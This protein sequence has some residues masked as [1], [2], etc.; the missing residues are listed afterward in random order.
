ML[1]K[2]LKKVTKRAKPKA[3]KSG[4]R[5]IAASPG[6]ARVNNYGTTGSRKGSRKLMG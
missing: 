6:Q 4:T 2:A 3:K 1:R 5:K